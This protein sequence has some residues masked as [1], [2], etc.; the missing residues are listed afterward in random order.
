[1]I[2]RKIAG[3]TLIEV[4]ITVLI[5]AVGMLGMA[6]LQVK[7]LNTS[8]ESYSKSQA[9][10]MV[11]GISDL[12]R[13]EYEYI[14]SSEAGNDTYTSNLEWCANPPAECTGASCTKEEV[15][16]NN[17]AQSCTALL[18][19]GI[20]AAKMGA[21]CQDI[22]AGDGDPCS[23]GSLHVIYASW[24]PDV[25]EDTDGDS[26]YTGPT[27][28]CQTEFNLGSNEDCVFVELIP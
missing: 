2:Q 12:M 22:L 25:R 10:A 13:A 4:L 15:A 21:A 16:K 23:P 28:R 19:T 27:T 11:E 26:T 5:M 24:Q 6:A 9:V 17:I 8:Q 18:N 20:P 1:M 7:A 14:H 3:V